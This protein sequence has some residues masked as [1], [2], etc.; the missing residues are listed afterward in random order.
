MSGTVFTRREMLRRA[1]ALAAASALYAKLPGQSR[2]QRPN[3]LLISVDTLRADHMSLYGYARPTT[4]FIDRLARDGVFFRHAYSATAWTGSSHASLFT[5]VYPPVH[6]M[7]HQE[8]K[9]APGWPTLAGYLKSMGYSTH[10]IVSGPM[11]ETRLGFGQGFDEF[12]ESTYKSKL[13]LA[14]LRKEVDYPKITEDKALEEIYLYKTQTG[15]VVREAAERFLQSAPADPWFLFLHLWDVHGDYN[16]PPQ[17]NVFDPDYTGWLKAD[18]KD[19]RIKEGLAERDLEHFKALYDGEVLWTDYQIGLLL[20]TLRQLPQA[21]NTCVILFSDHGEEFFEYGNKGH[22]HHLHD[23]LI[24][25]PLIFYWPGRL[26]PCVVDHPVSL[27]DVAPTLFALLGAERPAHFQGQSLI[28]ALEG[29]SGELQPTPLFGSLFFRGRSQ[30]YTLKHPLK[31]IQDT[32][33]GELFLY[34]LA[35]DSMERQNLAPQFKSVAQKQNDELR[36]WWEACEKL[37]AGLPGSLPLGA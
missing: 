37:R 15:P 20:N 30:V 16:P 8:M 24:R 11:V 35:I 25:V 18:M 7:H 13:D 34:N 32:T 29:R 2:P 1:A 9:L 31:L 22:G 4:P 12:D 17:F 23:I 19:E 26:S 14:A 3:I 36:R 6:Q 21:D 33:T 10:A 27:L 28:P 5:G